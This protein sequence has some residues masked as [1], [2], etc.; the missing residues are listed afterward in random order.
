MRRILRFFK[1]AHTAFRSTVQPSGA[2][3]GIGLCC[4][5]SICGQ[6]SA[7]YATPPV[8]TE[9]AAQ[10]NAIGYPISAATLGLGPNPV[11]SRSDIPTVDA[12][13]QGF[14]DSQQVKPTQYLSDMGYQ[15][16]CQAESNPCAY[17]CNRCD[18]NWYLGF[19][20]LMFRREGDRRFSLTSGTSLNDLE[21]EFGGRVTLGKMCDCV[22]AYEFVYAGPFKWTRFSDVTG[23]A[24]VDSRFVTGVFGGV[25]S[26]FFNDN[27]EP[28]S[29]FNDADRHLQ[30]WKMRS[31]SFEL[32]R[33]RWAWDAVSTLIGMRY[34]NYEEDYSLEAEFNNSADFS[35]YRDQVQNNLIGPQIGG[36]IFFLYSMKT[37]VSLRGKA[38][39]FANIAS[40]ESRLNANWGPTPAD[41][42][43]IA[44][45]PD[46]IAVPLNNVVFSNGKD[47]TDFA[48]LFELGVFGHYQCTP[49]VRFSGGYEVWY[50]TGLATVPGQ[51]QPF[52]T[53]GTG[54]ALRMREDLI[55]HGFNVNV[56]MFF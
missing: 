27:G 41:N 11:S 8:R 23:N 39:A 44:G 32:N 25:T 13:F 14:G 34:F 6:A 1:I 52:L 42:P 33:R 47:R 19:D 9:M 28:Y 46:P 51:R 36:D 15:E 38:G 22:N 4:A 55:L 43:L 20:A 29:Y 49:S 7:Q 21:F 45:V 40:R 50:A 16:Y 10:Q 35:F 5:M 37:S 54:T 26:G 53:L 17:S 12:G 2:V 24:N 30:T 3:I 31:Q 48:G 56:L 18:I